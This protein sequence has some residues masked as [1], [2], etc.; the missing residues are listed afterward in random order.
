LSNK[1]G[2]VEKWVK[3]YAQ[4]PFD[5]IEHFMSE[6]NSIKNDIETRLKIKLDID[7]NNSLVTI[8]P[9]SNETSPADMMKAKDVIQ[10]ISIGFSK[11]DI[12]DLLDEDSVLLIIDIKSKVGDSANH[13]KR[14]MGRI[15]GEDG[16]AK[17]TIEE[18]TGTIIHVGNNMVGIIGDYDRAIIAQHGI[19]LL[20]EGK[21]HSTVYKRLESMMRDVRKRD[22]TSIWQKRDLK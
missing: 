19:D 18:I 8:E 7:R 10:A 12:I 4:L 15:I 17:K 21:M 2:R 3:V 1:E 20:I 9:I 11:E 14:V 22:L 16:R 6:F 13:I 5:N